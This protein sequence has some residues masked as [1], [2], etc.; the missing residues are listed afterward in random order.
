MPATFPSAPPLLTR[1]DAVAPRQTATAVLCSTPQLR[2]IIPLTPAP[3]RAWERPRGRHNPKGH[4]P[5]TAVTEQ[6]WLT[7]PGAA[8]REQGASHAPV[9]PS[10]P[11]LWPRERGVFPSIWAVPSVPGPSEPQHQ[12]T[13]TK[14]PPTSKICA[15]ICDAG[16]ADPRCPLL[17]SKPSRRWQYY[18]CKQEDVEINFFFLLFF[19]FL[20]QTFVTPEQLPAESLPCWKTLGRS[21]RAR[22]CGRAGCCRRGAASLRGA[23]SCQGHGAS[24]TRAK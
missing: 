19:F 10:H 2:P 3:H 14:Q 11:S 21:S 13:K 18:P 7:S 24:C 12:C 23:D 9:S 5:G 17:L 16:G 1:R 22:S 20:S 6:G 15:Q 8:G 4:W